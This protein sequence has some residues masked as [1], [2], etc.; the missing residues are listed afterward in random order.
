MTFDEEEETVTFR[1]KTALTPGSAT[2]FVEYVGSLND[3]MRG[4]YR[5]KYC[6][7]SDPDKELY[8][9][10]TQFEVCHNLWLQYR[11][12]SMSIF[13]SVVQSLSQ[14]LVLFVLQLQYV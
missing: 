2:L 4:F 13:G 12:Y 5:S 1:F 11:V 14:V 7:P 9:A 8:A 10:V 6:L 3:K